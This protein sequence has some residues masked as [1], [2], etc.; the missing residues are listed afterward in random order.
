MLM[1]KTSSNVVISFWELFESINLSLE[2]NP[3]KLPA[4][5]IFSL[6]INWVPGKNEELFQVYILRIDQI[7]ESITS[8]ISILKTS[9]FGTE[10]KARM[11]WRGRT[12]HWGEGFITGDKE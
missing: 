12:Y 3:K 10:T 6:A 1:V 8:S 7:M 2:S 11:R 4:I 9:I 5:T